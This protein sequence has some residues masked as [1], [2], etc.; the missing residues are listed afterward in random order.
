MKASEMNAAFGLAQLDKLD[1]FKA[2]ILAGEGGGGVR[3]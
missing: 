3:L 1:R 2:E